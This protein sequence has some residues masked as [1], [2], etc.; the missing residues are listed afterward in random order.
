MRTRS[1][2]ARVSVGTAKFREIV[3]GAQTGRARRGPDR[4]RARRMALGFC[5]S[6][7]VSR[8]I[9]ELRDVAQAI[10]GGRARAAADALRAGRSRRSRDGTASHDRAARG[11]TVGARVRRRAA[12]RGDRIARRRHRRRERARRRRSR[13]NESARRLIVARRR[14]VPF[15]TDLLPHERLVREAVRGAM[16]GIATEPAELA[17]STIGRCSLTARPLPDGGAVL[18]VMDLTTRRRLETIRRDFVANVSHELKTPLTVIGGFAET[19]RDRD[20]SRRR[21]RSVSSRRSKRTRG[22]CSASSTTCSTSRATNRAAG[23]R[24]SCRTISPAS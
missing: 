4:R 23:F 11:A 3:S 21:P 7:S 15:S 17:S 12:Q 10:A 2:Y 18:A 9:I 16:S 1:G 5:F 6:R 19:L 14:P 13:L 24:T 22:A 20:L 8:P